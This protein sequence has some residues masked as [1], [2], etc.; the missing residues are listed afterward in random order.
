[1]EA[2]HLIKRHRL[3]DALGE[4]DMG[5]GEGAEQQIAIVEGAGIGTEYLAGPVG[6]RRVNDNGA[7]W[8]LAGFEQMDE[9]GEKLLRPLDGKGGDQQHAVRIDCRPHLG[10]QL[11]ATALF[12]YLLA[13]GVAVGGFH[14]HVVPTGRRLRRR[15]QQLVVRPE[16]A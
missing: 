16:I 3:L 11:R 12:G 5:R 14:H 1:M 6:K 7:G 9:V 4:A 13:I 15:L 2:M 8:Q 10:A